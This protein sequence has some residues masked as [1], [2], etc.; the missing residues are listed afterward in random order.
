MRT[1]LTK[2]VVAA[3]TSA[4]ISSIAAAQNLEEVTVQATRIPNTKT[5]GYTASGVPIVRISRL[6]A[7]AARKSAK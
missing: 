5:V 3:I 2:V 1:I 4:I 7:A 6:E